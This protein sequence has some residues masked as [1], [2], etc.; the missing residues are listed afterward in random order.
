VHIR[1]FASPIYK[2]GVRLENDGEFNN[3]LENNLTKNI[4]MANWLNEIKILLI[5][6]TTDFSKQEKENISVG[7]LIN[8]IEKIEGNFIIDDDVLRSK[9]EYVI[10][11]IPNKAGGKRI[12]YQTKHLNEITNLQTFVEEKF[13]F[14]KRGKYKRRYIS[15][16]IPLG[17][18][19]GL[20]FGAAIGKIGLSLLIGM[21]I[22]ML[23]GFLVGNYLDKKAEMDH[24]VL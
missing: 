20:P 5:N 3:Q 6:K 16:G 1:K 9:I 2:L 21:P 19:L 23:I 4:K 8:L 24:R 13:N 17:M 10:T 7:Y 22:G 15:L 12:N 18:T 14:V 11:E